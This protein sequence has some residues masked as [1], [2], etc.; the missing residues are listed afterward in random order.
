MHQVI[1]VGV[2]FSP[3]SHEALHEALELAVTEHTLEVHIAHV[4]SLASVANDG[5]SWPIAAEQEEVLER[6]VRVARD[7]LAMFSKRP[8]VFVHSSIGSPTRD[9][10]E[11]AG[12]LG[13]DLLVIGPPAQGFER[14]LFGSVGGRLT[15]IANCSVL[16][17]RP[18]GDGRVGCPDCD[19]ARQ[20][21]GRR[22]LW[23]A[24]HSGRELYAEIDT[25]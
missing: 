19:S 6:L 20:T 22:N 2:D 17:V 25:R 4:Q 16:V 3:G 23:C 9:L 5:Y 18:R 14:F 8:R 21:S 7:A 11:L 24:A 13:A 15:K 10:A 12:D 1:L